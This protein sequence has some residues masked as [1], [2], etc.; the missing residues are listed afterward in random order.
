MRIKSLRLTSQ[1]FFFIFSILGIVGIA[2]T[3]L[4]YPFFFCYACP[5]AVAACPIGLMEHAAIDIVMI[6]VI[7][8]LVLFAYTFGFLAIV[9]LIFGR[10]F[11]GWACPIGFLQDATNKLREKTIKKMIG[12]K[13][14]IDGDK[15]KYLKYLFIPI[16]PI[17]SY[18][19]LD[20]LY[21]RFCPVGGI[22]G[23]LPSLLLFPNKWTPSTY[24]PIKIVSI[25]LFFVLVAVI[26]KGWCR[27]LCPVGA[28]FAP[29]NKVSRAKLKKTEE[30]VGCEEEGCSKVCPMQIEEPGEKD[31]PECILCGRCVDECEAGGLDL[32]LK[33]WKDE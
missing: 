20:L 4:I 17:S 29:F 18:I 23:T 30:C 10:G 6:G 16:I 22:T 26:G 19:T 25:I 24:F 7:E 5:Y 3:G 31:D 14:D 8:G 2:M 11:C 28:I 12:E 32:K 1:T 9:G 13:G 21:T 33:G 27:F 15:L